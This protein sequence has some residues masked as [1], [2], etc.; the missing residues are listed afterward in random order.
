MTTASRGSIAAGQSLGDYRI[1]EQIGRGGMGAV[2]RALQP[3]LER[4]VAI[5]V[6]PAL[7]AADEEWRDRFRREAR[8]VA[9]LNHPHIL[10][11]YD[12]GEEDGLPYLVCELVEGGTLEGKLIET[13][14]PL[15]LHE[16]VSL[17]APVADA[18]DYAHR[19]GVLHRDVKPSNVLLTS[20]GVPILADFGVARMLDSVSSLGGEGGGGTG[21][22]TEPGLLQG[23]PAYMAPEH[24][25]GEP[26]GQPADIYALAVVAYQLLTGRVPFGGDTPLATL[27]AHVNA[28]L[29]AAGALNPA[30]PAAAEAAL[31]RGLAKNANERF[32]TAG[33][34]VAALEAAIAPAGVPAAAT[35]EREGPATSAGTAALPRARGAGRRRA[36]VLAA[37]GLTTVLAGGAMAVAAVWEVPAYQAWLSPIQRGGPGA[38]T[39]VAS[40]SPAPA[41]ATPAP[42]LAP[43]ATAA[44][45]AS[46]QPTPPAPPPTA[47]QAWAD[48]TD[49]LD[50][51]WGADWPKTIALIDAFRTQFPTHPAATQKLYAALVSYGELRVSQGARADGVAQLERARSLQPGRG[52]AP[53]LLRALTPTPAPSGTRPPPSVTA[54]RPAATAVPTVAPSVVPTQAPAAAP[55]QATA[56]PTRAPTLA[57]TV[58]PTEAPT[59]APSATAAPT[60]TRPSSPPP[61]STPAPTPI[62]AP[63]TVVL[64]DSFDDPARGV[65]PT[66]PSGTALRQYENGA[67]VMRRVDPVVGTTGAVLPGFYKDMTLAVDVHV[68][69]EVQNRAVSASCRRVTIGTSFAEYEFRLYPS[70]GSADL[71]RRDAGEAGAIRVTYAQLAPLKQYPS[72]TR[73]N[74]SNHVELTCAGD[75]IVV[76]VN[77]VNIISVRDATYREGALALSVI[78]ESAVRADAAFENLAVIQR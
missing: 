8:L 69:G 16:A 62:P 4:E 52:E 38:S 68:E 78:A 63:G 72:I 24:A 31:S 64:Q 70:P 71:R 58:A 29:P 17:L 77:G 6:L 46:P 73:G 57:P 34:L 28:P 35:A 50:V 40:P 10:T 51:T 45:T 33:A 47:D 44:A 37:L 48:V 36:A 7:A 9:R 30:I 19:H 12:Y 2:Y 32:A 76:W 74:G 5:K 26:V 11:V 49:D 67:Y 14:Q 56:A 13:G 55:V 20:D 27:L 22:L 75:V 39:V 23:T 53:A 42:T 61:T 15:P 54:T 65:L 18:L 21:T 41:V 3:G 66:T 60:N 25:T 59:T 43:S 1:L